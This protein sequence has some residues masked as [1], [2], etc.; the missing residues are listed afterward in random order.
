MRNENI[1]NVAIIAH[2]DHG[3]TTLVD[4]LLRQSGVFR[5]NEQVQDRVMDSGDLE[6]ERG[7]TILSKNTAVNYKGV[8]INIV[9]TPGHADFGGEVERIL[10]MVDGVVLLVDAFEGCMPQTRFVLG[11]ALALGKVPVVVVNKVDRPGARP[12]EVV[13]ETLE[14]FMDLGATAEQLDFPVVYASARDGYSGLDPDNLGTD[15]Q[16]LFD[17]ILSTVP[18]PSG[19]PSAPLQILFSTIDYDDYVGRIGVGRIVRGTAKRNE[20]VTL[21]GG[22]KEDRREVKLSRLY[23]FEGLKR[24]EIEEAAAGEIVAV[25]G[26]TGLSIGETACDPEH[27]EPL[28]FVHIDEPTVSMMFLVNDSPFAGKEGKYVTSRNLRDRLFKEVETNVAMRVEE[29]DSTDM[30]KVSGRGELHL[31]ILIEQMRRQDYEFAV[32]RPRVIMKTDER[33]KLLEPME[34]LTIDVPQE[35]VGA[36][37]E[38]LGQRKA[39]LVNMLSQTDGSTT[40]LIFTI[41]ARS[42]LGYRSELLTDTRGNGVMSHIFHGYAPYKGDIAERTH[43]SLICHETGETTSYGLFNTQERGRLF[44]G[45]GVPVYEGEI[46]GECARN[47][48]IVVNV[49]KKKHVTNMRAA[50][51]DEALRL[52]PPLQLSLEQCIE[53]IADD[54]LVEV[55]PKSIRLRKKLLTKDARVKQANR[56]QS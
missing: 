21:C 51:S 54:E 1:R 13:D 24:V 10:Q 14:L 4:Q 9:D 55:T 49:C 7:I 38:K 18:A 19:D 12:L 11:K 48:D 39:E 47:E 41:P 44:I 17:T 40:R 23:R 25:A 2:V 42:L 29:T 33:G 46:V 3:K 43:G 6:R 36:V 34:E 27:V 32:S 30:F 5:A 35:F 15:M 52:T 53:F 31:S 50:G 45:P 28:P 26:V 20:I 16:P 56:S 22:M 8:R 37:M